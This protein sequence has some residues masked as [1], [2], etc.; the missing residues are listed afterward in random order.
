MK[1][2]I[3]VGLLASAMA[4]VHLVLVQAGRAVGSATWG[5][6]RNLITLASSADRISHL[7]ALG[8]LDRL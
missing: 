6:A 3:L 7:S 8:R 2:L 1:R 5:D 4:L